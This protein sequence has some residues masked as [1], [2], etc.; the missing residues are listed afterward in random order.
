MPKPQ[1]RR[2]GSEHHAYAGG[3]LGEQRR[4]S[5][6]RKSGW[7]WTIPKVSP[8]FTLADALNDNK[9]FLVGECICANGINYAIK[10]ALLNKLSSCSSVPA[11]MVCPNGGDEDLGAI[12]KDGGGHGGANASTY[13]HGDPS[14]PGAKSS[15][16]PVWPNNDG[17]MGCG[18]GLAAARGWPGGHWPWIYFC[19]RRDNNQ[20]HPQISVFSFTCPPKSCSSKILPRVIGA[21]VFQNG[22]VH[23]QMHVPFCPTVPHYRLLPPFHS[24]AGKREGQMVPLI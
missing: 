8:P 3:A 13:S 18:H 5:A 23:V 1:I 24:G 19:W 11:T 16:Q 6:Y 21:L 12:T 22:N 9:R 20:L 14:L 4:A 2:P 15:A 17:A 7:D 10:R